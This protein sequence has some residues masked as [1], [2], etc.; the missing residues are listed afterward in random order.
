MAEKA[1]VS[2]VYGLKKV[3][4]SYLIT[5]DFW[6]TDGVGGSDV[7]TVV[8]SSTNLV[9]LL[10]SWRSRIREAIIEYADTNWDRTIDEVLF[11]D[12]SLIGV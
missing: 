5:V 6:A 4:G 7:G 8:V 9:P 2:Q 1:Q 12:L 3:G 10:P 11:L